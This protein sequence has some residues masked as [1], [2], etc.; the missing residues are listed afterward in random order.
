MDV[1][2]LEGEV[3]IQCPICGEWY[4]AD[5]SEKGQP[6]IECEAKGNPYLNRIVKG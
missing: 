6:C 5:P 3:P 1:E 4:A 2:C